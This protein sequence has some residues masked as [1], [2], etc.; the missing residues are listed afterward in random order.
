MKRHLDDHPR[1]GQTLERN[2]ARAQRPNAS[3]DDRE[4]VARA[5]GAK[6]EHLAERFG[7]RHEQ[8]RG[9]SQAPVG[10]VGFGRGHRLHGGLVRRGR[11]LFLAVA[12]V[13][14]FDPCA[15]QHFLQLAD[16][17]GPVLVLF[18]EVHEPTVFTA[19]QGESA[20][21]QVLLGRI[22][23]QF[24][25]LRL[26]GRNQLGLTNHVARL[27]PCQRGGAPLRQRQRPC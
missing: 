7:S 1:P 21:G 5:G 9:E 11:G 12:Q 13:R 18:A 8:H 24:A 22:D 6:R 4:I 14:Q 23:L 17:G 2:L 3:E 10:V 27:Q 16:K 19:E 25:K 20:A 15:G 26:A